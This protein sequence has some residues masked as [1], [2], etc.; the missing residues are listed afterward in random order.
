MKKLS[1]RTNMLT[2]SV[3]AYCTCS[4]FT[5]KGR[6]SCGGKVNME[7]DVNTEYMFQRDAYRVNATGWSG[8]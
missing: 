4:G 1:R 7:T 3:E 8:K 6:C 5:C 2:S